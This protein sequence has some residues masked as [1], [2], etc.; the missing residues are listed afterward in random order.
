MFKAI[1][2]NKSED[3]IEAIAKYYDYLEIQPV[4]NNNFMIAKGIAQDEEELRDMN[5]YIVNLGEKL[6]IPVAATGD[7]HFLNPEDEVYRRIIMAGKGFSDAD[8][9]PPLYLRTTDDMLREF[10]YLGTQK[11]HEVVIGVPNAI[12]DS[13]DEILPI[14]K[15]TSP[16]RIEG[17]DDELRDMCFKKARNIYG[18]DLPEIVEE[19]LE[20]EL[21]SIISNGYSVMYII[22]QKLV[23]KSLEDGYLVGSRGSVGSSFAATMSDITE[24]NPLPPHYVCKH[25]KHSTFITDGSI[26]SGADLPDRDCPECGKAYKKKMV[27]IFHLQPS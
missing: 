25:C 7:V 24:V 21:N 26:G 15:E 10:K 8:N 27:M 1:L 4:G 5:R 9:Q 11:A 18:D 20:T 14:P 23:V 19:R 16:P 2:S 3:E 6:D 17:S 13:V 12:A 22:S